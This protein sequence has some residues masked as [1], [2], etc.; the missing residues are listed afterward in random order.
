MNG[1]GTADQGDC[2]QINP[3]ADFSA[4]DYDE[5]KDIFFKELTTMK[6][7]IYFNGNKVAESAE[8]EAVVGSTPALP[9]TM[10]RDFCAYTYQSATIQ[11]GQ[12]AE[13]VDIVWNGPFVV[14]ADAASAKWYNMTV[15][16]ADT[17]VGYDT[18]SDPNVKT[19][20][21][22]AKPN[23]LWAFLGDPYSGISII[24]GANTGLTLG[25]QDSPE[26]MNL[27]AE[28]E[29]KWFPQVSANRTDGFYLKNSIS[30]Q[31]P[32]HRTGSGLLLNWDGADAGS[33]FVVE[34]PRVEVTYIIKY[35]GTVIGTVNSGVVL[36]QEAALP[37]SEKRDYCEYTYAPQTITAGITEVEVNVTWNGPTALYADRASVANW[38][39]LSIRGNWY[40]TS[41]NVDADG[42]LKTVNANALG[43]VE[44]A[45]QWA[46]VGDPYHIQLFNKAQENN[47]GYSDAAK[48]NGG[49]PAFQSAT[50]YWTIKKST[51][52]IA[53]SFMLTVPGTNLQIN[54]FGGE[55]GSLKFWN[56][57]GTAD[58]GSAF[59]IFDVPTDFS[60]YASDLAP[61]FEATGY[62]S[63]KD[64][65]KTAAGWNASL[66]TTCTFEQYKKLRDAV[67]ALSYPDSYIVPETGYY[68]IRSNYYAGEYIGLKATTLYGNYTATADIQGAPTV[69]K[70]TRNGNQYSLQVQGKYIQAPT[71]ST[72]VG[73]SDANEVFFTPAV[74]K[75]GVV[76]FSN[77][78]SDATYSYL[79]H[80]GAGDVVGWVLG[81]DASHWVL[82]DAT[83]IT[84]NI[85]DAG[86]ATLNVPFAVTIPDGVKAYTATTDGKALTMD[87]VT[88]TTIPAGT[89]VILEGNGGD[90]TFVIA[91]ANTDAA[92][93]SDLVGN[94][95]ES[96]V[97]VGNYV[98]QKQEKVGFF[99]V[100]DEPKAIKANRAYLSVPSGS[101]VKAFYFGD[102]ED[103][104]GA[105]DNGHLTMDNAEIYNLAG[106]RVKKLQRGVNIV[107]STQRGASHLK[108]G[109][110]VLVK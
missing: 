86:Y 75:A 59:T 43:L 81:A 69:V 87:E 104:I 31:R 47:F 110:K 16:N 94:Y 35:N 96:T 98:L 27:S 89:A 73:L 91:A 5:A 33:T 32:N 77:T 64:E 51:S 70:L 11:S 40:V 54:Q 53:G 36:D 29:I 10:K 71:N 46:F 25:Y 17:F 93:S 50:S 83:S 18:T 103:A 58:V 9:E 88:S 105:I 3:V 62:F 92:I 6:Y 38:Q 72:P 108:N 99:Q 13:R 14:S 68:R 15:R 30:G 102:A 63:L 56:F 41:S 39:N 78:T 74:P 34:D 90:Y 8:V 60:T 107:R 4:A 65:V 19:G 44:D 100:Q 80:R 23:Q 1:W 28:N 42:A 85:S 106:Q 101:P 95:T 22:N 57:G 21:S 109:K 84:V 24:N 37:A 79:H 52:T 61:Y 76:A 7:E 26:G 67:D 20:A 2:M 82:E 66:K 97:S 45:Y 49:V 55:G 12:T 48:E